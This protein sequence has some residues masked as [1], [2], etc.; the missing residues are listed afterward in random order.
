MGTTSG[1]QETSSLSTSNTEKEKEKNMNTRSNI[2]TWDTLLVKHRG[3]HH[4]HL[5]DDRHLRHHQE[6]DD[7]LIRLPDLLL[8]GQVEHGVGGEADH[9]EEA[10]VGALQD[11]EPKLHH[12]QTR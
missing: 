8:P 1:W 12:H 4:H 10:E 7:Q 9:E 11:P 2:S 5:V 6:V 3:R